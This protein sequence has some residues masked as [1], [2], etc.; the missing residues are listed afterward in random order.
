MNFIKIVLLLLLFFSL[1]VVCQSIDSEIPISARTVSNFNT[2][3]LTSII[4]NSTIGLM[5]GGSFE[6]THGFPILENDI[7]SINLSIYVSEITDGSYKFIELYNNTASAVTFSSIVHN[8]DD[9]DPGTID[10]GYFSLSNITIQANSF[11]IISGSAES[12]FKNNWYGVGNDFP[13][14]ANTTYVQQA[15]DRI[16]AGG[17]GGAYSVFTGTDNGDGSNNFTDGA[18]FY[19]AGGSNRVYRVSSLT[20]S[21]GWTTDVN[22]NATPGQLEGSQLPLPV[23]LVLF[24]GSLTDS[25]T[26]KLSWQTATEVNNFGFE[27]ERMTE[28]TLSGVEDWENI[29]FVQGHGTT[30]S[31]KEYSFVDNLTLNPNLN[32][33]SYRLKQID[34]DG[35]FAFSKEITVDL[36]SITGVDDENIPNEFSLSQNYPNPFNPSTTIKFGLPVNSKVKLE[37]Y[38]ILGQR[39]AALINKEMNAGYHY[40]EWDGSNI[41]S[42]IY[43]YRIITP[44]SVKTK[45]LILLK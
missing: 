43:F 13:D 9:S 37:V 6:V 38:N 23:E 30:N 3:E 14:P 19:A 5:S 22:S 41:S 7:S 31:P 1:D 35:T 11:L 27:I 15:Y 20:S 42:G 34:N 45:K 33:V 40:I 17:P 21:S 36:T 32:R 39:V 18:E 28:S 16:N 26:I 8:T 12:D 44:Q 29:G 4:G 25:S 10:V 24:E 2:N